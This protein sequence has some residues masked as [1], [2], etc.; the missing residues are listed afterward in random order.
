MKPVITPKSQYNTKQSKTYLKYEK[1][2][3]DIE[4][5]KQFKA[6]LE[7]GLSKA[8]SKI[9]EELLPMQRE[10]NSLSRA[11]IIR[12]DELV[13][14]IGI[15]KFN[16]E[17]LESY[18]ADELD[19]L[20]DVFGHGDEALSKLYTKYA[21]LSVD[22][23]AEDEDIIATA[24]SFSELFGFEVDVKEFLEKGQTGYFEAHKE[25]IL[26][27]IYKQRD[28]FFET[29]QGQAKQ[30]DKKTSNKKAGDE[31]TMLAK[32]ARSVYMRL[33]KKFHPDLEKDII[34]KEQN[35]EIT[36]QVTKAY[37]ENDFFELL[38]LQITYLD[39]NEKDAE[40]IADDMLKR[41]IKLL[42]KQLDELNASI[43]ETHFT[44]GNAIADFIDKNGKFS[45]Q[46]FAARRRDIEKQNASLKS[47][48]ADSKND[49]KD[50]LKIK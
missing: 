12:L 15:G 9:N 17:W 13:T 35:N 4:K 25:K 46:K 28:A 20:L 16:R 2:L 30:K 34:K 1:L 43:H 44:S 26:E 24:K 14:E 33:I 11:Y 45:P 18:M 48:L 50:G 22:D 8:H 40:A 29:E 27:N 49:L 37:Q 23:I 38:K 31:D 10:V 39:D 6:N 7:T 36:K 21:D 42:K 41:Y 47:T 3:A 5:Q 19:S 32:D